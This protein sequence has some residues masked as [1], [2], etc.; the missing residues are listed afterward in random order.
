MTL[1][2]A[3]ATRLVADVVCEMQTGVATGGS[4]TTL[5]DTSLTAPDDF[6]NGGTIWLL[7]GLNAGKTAIVTDFV[8]STGTFTFATLTQVCA[9]DDQYE[10]ATASINR[11]M[12]RRSVNL[13]LQGMGPVLNVDA[14][15]DGVAD[16]VEYNLPAGVRHVKRVL[17]G[18][19]TGTGDYSHRQWEEYNGKLRF[20]ANLPSASDTITL[21]YENAPAFLDADTDTISDYVPIE[22]L[23]WEAAIY[24]LRSRVNLVGAD[25]TALASKLGEAQQMAALMRSRYPMRTMTRQP[26]LASFG[27]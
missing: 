10:S 22:R 15:L 7:T 9:A 6:Y 18:D 2:L 8:N 23:K 21:F 25:D 11:Q 24:A 4:A 12:L 5:A 14:T 20:M 26:N 13:A 19:G 3:E 17:V 27:S 1:T 16:Q